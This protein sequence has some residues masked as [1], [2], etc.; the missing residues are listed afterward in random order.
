MRTDIGRYAIL[1]EW[2]LDA[3]VSSHAIRLFGLLAAKYADREGSCHPG[4]QAL[5]AQMGVR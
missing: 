5:A 4:R 3:G 2:L 1:P